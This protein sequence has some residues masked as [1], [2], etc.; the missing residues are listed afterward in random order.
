MTLVTIDG[1]IGAGGADLGR[2]VSKMLG[3]DYVDRLILP[4]QA[5]GPQ[6]AD[7]ADAR[8]KLSDRIWTVFEKAVRGIALGNAAGDPYFASAEL[9]MYPLTWDSSPGAPMSHGIADEPD[10]PHSMQTLLKKGSGVLVQRAGAV[11]LKGHEQVLKIGVFASWEDRIAR[12][13][14]SQGLS[15]VTDAERAIREL[16]K[17]QSDY[18]QG[19][20]SAHPEDQSLYDLCLNTSREQ[21]NLAAVKVT[22]AARALGLSDAAVQPV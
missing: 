12:M 8:P 13:M 2:R 21:I 16:E 9:M 4:G 3:N 15:S 14:R 6:V 10:H 11:A 18:F 19:V 7:D 5:D 17:A 20:H 1:H 22:R